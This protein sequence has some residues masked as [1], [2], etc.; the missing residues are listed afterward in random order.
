MPADDSGIDVNQV[1]HIVRKAI[2]NIPGWEVKAEAAIGQFSFSKYLMWLDLSTR[3]D[4]LKNQ[5]VVNH[6]IESPR[7]PFIKQDDFPQPAQLDQRYQPQQLFTPLS[8]DSSQLAAVMSAALGRTFVLS[9]PPGTGKSQTITNMISQC[10]ADGKSV[11]F[12][13]EKM[14]ALEVVYRRLT[15]IG[16][17]ELCLQ[18]HSSKAQKMQVLDQ[19]R[20]R[21]QKNND[22]YFLS[23]QL[24]TTEWQKLSDKLIQSRDELN[25]HVNNLHTVHA[26]GWSLYAAMSDEL[27]Y[28]DTPH[29]RFPE[30]EI[31]TLTS[32]K[33]ELLNKTVTQAVSL[34]Q[35]VNENAKDVLDG[36]WSEKH[37]NPLYLG[38]E[39]CLRIE[40]TELL[41]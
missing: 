39:H 3:M 25:Q 20:E 12:V 17:S 16:L 2:V 4:Q 10:L 5:S 18:L 32:E 11:L 8:S 38:T 21:A 19:L 37:G 35:L 41:N 26:I 6:L 36:F 23:A 40:S 15:Q 28:R 34:R 13:S 27:C 24:K 22:P 31:S 1:L 14:A 33:R 9:G 7:E 30:I 29:L